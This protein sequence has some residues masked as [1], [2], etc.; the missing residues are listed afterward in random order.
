[1]RNLELEKIFFTFHGLSH[2]G[3][4]LWVGFQGADFGTEFSVQYFIRKCPYDQDLWKEWRERE[5]NWAEVR[6][7]EISEKILHVAPELK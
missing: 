2:A 3:M 1:M 6:S 5:H 4:L 7:G